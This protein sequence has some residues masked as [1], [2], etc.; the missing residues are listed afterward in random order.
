MDRVRSW[1]AW[2]LRY[3]ADRI[4]PSTAFRAIGWHLRFVRGK[5]AVIEEHGAGVRLWYRTDEWDDA[6]PPE[7]ER[8]SLADAIIAIRNEIL[9]RTGS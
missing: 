3:L 5:G 9:D 8:V 6:F 2:R 4:S 7:P 1:L